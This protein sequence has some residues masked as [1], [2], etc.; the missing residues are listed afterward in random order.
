MK[1]LY[2]KDEEMNKGKF[3]L[4]CK[5]YAFEETNRKSKH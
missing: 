1:C 5:K 4:Y 3:G 2:H